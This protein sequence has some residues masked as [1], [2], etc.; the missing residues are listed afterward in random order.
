MPLPAKATLVA[1][2]Q[3]ACNGDRNLLLTY[4]AMG[5]FEF[6]RRAHPTTDP[7][8]LAG[9]FL[10]Q[11]CIDEDGY[12]NDFVHPVASILPPLL[13]DCGCSLQLGRL[14]ELADLLRSGDATATT[15]ATLLRDL[16]G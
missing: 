16:C 15:I 5:W 9:E 6:M 11:M 8:E 7:F 3:N 12:F 13:K 1:F 14:V 10:M 2:V 4:K